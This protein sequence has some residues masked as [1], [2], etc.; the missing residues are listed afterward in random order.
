[1][2]SS[3][4]TPVASK[5][6]KKKKSKIEKRRPKKGEEEESGNGEKGRGIERERIGD[7]DTLIS[8]GCP[9]G[10]REASSNS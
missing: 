8:R 9:E 4:T 2:I 3:Y 7:R 10:R 5:K 1:M 6:K